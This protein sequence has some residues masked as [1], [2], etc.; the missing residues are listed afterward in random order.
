MMETD[1]DF[2]TT[3]R[4][5]RL[6]RLVMGGGGDGGQ[7]TPHQVPRLDQALARAGPESDLAHGVLQM[8]DRGFAGGKGQHLG[9][10]HQG[11]TQKR[12]AAVKWWVVEA[13]W[14]SNGGCAVWIS[15][16]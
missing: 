7:E 2:Q 3:L 14:W 10:T 11:V 9:T 5:T 16:L 4:W 1:D 15:T 6:V 12:V 13:G 8:G